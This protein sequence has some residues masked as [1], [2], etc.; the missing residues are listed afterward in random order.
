MLEQNSEQIDKI[1]LMVHDF[2]TLSLSA[3]LSF[4]SVAREGASARLQIGWGWP[5]QV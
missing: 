2:R 3:L 1:E 4:H 5:N